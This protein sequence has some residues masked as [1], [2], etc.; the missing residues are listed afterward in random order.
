M[1]L[2][3]IKGCFATFKYLLLQS[4]LAMRQPYT[5]ALMIFQLFISILIQAERLLTLC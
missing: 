1:E 5:N 2:E 4:L 3:K